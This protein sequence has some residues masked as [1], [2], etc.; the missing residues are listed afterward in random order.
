MQLAAIDIG[1]IGLYLLGML[2]VGW[3]ASKRIHSSS[4]YA[5]AGRGM[6]FPLLCGTLI[7]TTVGVAATMGNAGK[8]YTAGFAVLYVSLAYV[9]GY[10]L[11]AV[12]APRLRAARI[13]S[14]P[15][16]LQRFYGPR[17]RVVGGCV[18]LLVAVPVVAVQLAACG[19]IVT[20]FLPGLGLGFAE[21]V[22]IAG[23]VIVVYTLLGGL[24]G[25]RLYGPAA[26]GHHGGRHWPAVAA[27]TGR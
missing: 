27:D 13:D 7:G 18:L 2:G 24:A 10:C 21:A 6:R 11:M 8:A 5:V 1:V 16:V 20:G 22:L 19:L 9:L 23:A 25:C 15:D 12:I 4:D 26:G 14:L 17:M 3:L